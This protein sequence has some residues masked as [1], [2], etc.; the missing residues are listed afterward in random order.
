RECQDRCRCVT[1]G[2][3]YPRGAADLLPRH[4]QLG[5]AIGP[6][7]GMGA[8]VVPR[9][10][11][12]VR[13][14]VVG[15]QVHDLDA[16][17]QVVGDQGG[18]A[19]WQGEEDQVAVERA[20]GPGGLELPAGQRRQPSEVRVDLADEPSGIAVGRYRAELQTGVACDQ[21]EQPAPRAPPAPTTRAPRAAPPGPA[22]RRSDLF[23]A[24]PVLL[25][26][27][28]ASQQVLCMNY[29]AVE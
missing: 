19:G 11:P 20:A 10:R 16:V 2:N 3:G 12:S 24:G 14:P 9:P 17:L 21:P 5:Q 28:C 27:S 7:P 23:S 26:R 4:G 15:T 13:E 18:L 22:A 8:P 25:S 29:Y 6:V 1:A